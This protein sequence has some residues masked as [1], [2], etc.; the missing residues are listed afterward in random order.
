ME[1]DV[2]DLECPICAPGTPLAKAAGAMGGHPC[3]GCRGAFVPSE[4]AVA[5]RQRMSDGHP[6]PGA[7][8]LA[9]PSCGRWMAWRRLGKA[10]AATCP[11]CGGA[12]LS[13]AAVTAETLS[14]LGTATTRAPLR[15]GLRVPLWAVAA[16]GGLLLVGLLGKLILSRPRGGASAEAAPPGTA[17]QPSQPLLLPRLSGPPP[18]PLHGGRPVSWWQ[19]RLRTLRA[20]TDAEGKLLF[21]ETLRRAR[22][23][24]LTV[25]GDDALVLRVDGAAAGG[26]GRP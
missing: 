25:T 24:G 18:A 20:R 23:N 19:E 21:E 1:T 12:W 8:S 10:D 3:R 11:A 26:G 7:L 2:D 4:R 17:E 15:F 13:S 22:A 14:A 16:V 9:C 6:P 5:L